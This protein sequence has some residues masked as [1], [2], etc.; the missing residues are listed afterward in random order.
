MKELLYFDC[1]A[2]FGPRPSKHK[3]ERWSKEHLLEDLEL[4]AIAG[5]LVKQSIAQLPY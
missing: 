4:T 2:R 3:R 1:N 5:A